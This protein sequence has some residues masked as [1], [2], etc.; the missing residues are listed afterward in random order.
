MSVRYLCFAGAALLGVTAL[1]T[2]ATAEDEWQPGKYMTQALGRIMA[3]TR[4]VTQKTKFG[5]DDGSSCFMGALLKVGKQAESAIP[6]K[7]GTEYAFI[8]GGDDDVND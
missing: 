6:L 4:N 2:A 7:G 8:G 3:S 1:P 5:L